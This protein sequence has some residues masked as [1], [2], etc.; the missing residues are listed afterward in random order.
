[1]SKR[2]K[3]VRRMQQNPKAVRFDELCNFLESLGCR[4]RESGSHITFTF[5]GTGRIITV[6]R[7]IPFVLPIYVKNVLDLLDELGLIP[8]ID[9]EDTSEFDEGNHDNT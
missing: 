7:R 1:M 3:F 5:P 9:S 8:T 4:R 6:P 2:T